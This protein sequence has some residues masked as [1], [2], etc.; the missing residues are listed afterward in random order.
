MNGPSEKSQCLRPGDKLSLTGWLA[1]ESHHLRPS[2]L[3]LLGHVCYLCVCT[4]AWGEGNGTPLQYSCLE[5]PMD[6]EA[7][8][9]AVPRVAKGQTRL[10]RLSAQELQQ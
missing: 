8:R 6:G 9:A 10:K 2:L 5:T 4:R 7:W 1:S 3:A